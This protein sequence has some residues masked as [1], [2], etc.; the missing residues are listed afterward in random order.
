MNK[1]TLPKPNEPVWTVRWIP[2]ACGGFPVATGLRLSDA[3]SVAAKHE[4]IAR[5][6]SWAGRAE[7]ILSA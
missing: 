1:N 3:E 4:A 7:V 6:R 5:A 2:D